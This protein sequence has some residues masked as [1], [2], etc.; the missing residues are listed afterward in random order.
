MENQKD[1]EAL[2][3]S[4]SLK[5]EI[6]NKIRYGYESLIQEEIDSNDVNNSLLTEENK[7]INNSEK[8]LEKELVFDDDKAEELKEG[9]KNIPERKSTM[10]ISNL[11]TSYFGRRRR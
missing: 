4:L 9:S 7:L 10:N 5:L 1:I 11:G 3:Y 6:F 2:K 8:F